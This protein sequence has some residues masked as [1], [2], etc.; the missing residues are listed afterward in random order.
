MRSGAC[1]RISALVVLLSLF[2]LAI[3]GPVYGID[4]YYR[5]QELSSPERIQFEKERKLCIFP[6]RN[7]SGDKNIDFYSAGYA[8]VLYSGLK[9][10]VQVY[11]E[12][13]IPKSIQYAYG[14][15]TESTRIREGEWDA[16]KLEKLRK[17]EYN[18]TTSRDPRYLSLKV[19]PY[20]GEVA[21]DEGFIIPVS[22]KFDC[23]YAIYG[24]FEKK[25]TDEIRIQIRLRSS[26]DGS[27][28]EFSHKTS[29]RRSYQELGS[30]IEELR[31]T[32]LGK[33]TQTLSVKTSQQY[34]SLVFLDGNYI[35]KTPLRRTDILAGVHDVRVTKNGF[36]DW[37]GQVD[38]REGPKELNI[39]LEKDKKEGLITVTSEP[40]GAKVYL[41]SEYLGTTPLEKVPVKTGWNRIRFSLDEYV[42][43]FKGVEIK[44]GE[45]TE[46]F[47]K[48]RLG[49]S[50]SYYKNKKYL[51]L[52]HT[53]DDF[54]V[55]SLYGTLFFYAGYYYFN[56]RADQAF[57]SIRPTVTVTNL[58]G[59]ESLAQSS[60][61][62]QTFFM[63]YLYQEHVYRHARSE[64][65][66]Y[67]SLSGNF[68]RRTGV[69]GGLMLDAMGLMLALTVTFYALGL[70]SETVEVGTA[71][72]KTVPSYV[73][74]YDN[75]YEMESFAKFKMRF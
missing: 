28:K 24:E 37:I 46:A 5:F 62:Q 59:L 26:K 20:E 67:R 39:P 13:L 32:L 47:A 72:V 48:L 34:D 9:S 70:D 63:S 27:K 1:K 66:Y 21:P 53:Y 65:N 41:G 74:V 52:D 18:L 15:Q 6:L 54:A 38:L 2:P 7:L 73:K 23:F 57:E 10:L 61:N 16:K 17:G 33:T 3:F 30:I 56:Y 69:Q 12:S 40:S 68:G 60:P 42:D 43:K 71:P 22:R 44:K 31:K 25:G 45:V 64:F 4:E 55:Y 51:F 58:V 29:V 75:Q 19:Q 50:V 35:G 11:D 36:E 8:S 14:T 49:D